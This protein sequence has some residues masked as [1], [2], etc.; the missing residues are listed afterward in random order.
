M[1]EHQINCILRTTE[2]LHTEL[3][4]FLR[5]RFSNCLVNSD[6]RAA[7][8]VA[9]ALRH[10]EMLYESIERAKHNNLMM[11]QQTKIKVEITP[12]GQ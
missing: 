9:E 11:K 8:Q 4:E 1:T 2:K 7:V 6:G 10:I 12:E 5:G 3:D